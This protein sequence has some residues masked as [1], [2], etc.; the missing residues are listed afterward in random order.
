MKAAWDSANLVWKNRRNSRQT[1]SNEIISLP[2]IFFIYFTSARAA[3]Q[4]AG[5]YVC[6]RGNFAW[7]LNHNMASTTPDQTQAPF[8]TGINNTLVST[9]P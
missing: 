4:C 5:M 3:T 7:S 9:G 6:V 8:P 1:I 2:F